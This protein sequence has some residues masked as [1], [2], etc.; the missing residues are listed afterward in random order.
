M[1]G[2]HLLWALLAAACFAA[3]SAALAR[4]V[5]YVLTGESRVVVVCEGC[6]A[7]AAPAET[8]SGS[9]DVTEMPV[10]A[11]YSVDAITSLNL[12]SAHSGFIGTGFLQRLGADRMAM[13][14]QGHLNGADMLLTSG[15]R[16]PAQAGE[17]RM[18][19]FSP[20][21]AATGVRVTLVATPSNADANDADGDGVPDEL[22][23]CSY[24]S[25]STQ[26]DSDGDGVGDA[27]DGCPDTPAGETTITG[28]CSLSQRCPCD[29][30][31]ADKEWDGQRDYVQCVGRELKTLRQRKHI[32]R[33][34]VR[35][36]LQ[37]AVRSGCGRK[38]LALL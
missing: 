10:P 33:S 2:R 38:V 35:R 4:T 22:D 12:Q 25:N 3:P 11:E 37:D 18:Q 16:Q 29:G 21:G 14:I 30:P 27:C 31:S 17:I 15:R 5:H 7:K 8:L 6:D 20:K 1:S 9:F 36:I 24:I 26:L 34:E 13:V 32:D 28:G 23:N 19:L